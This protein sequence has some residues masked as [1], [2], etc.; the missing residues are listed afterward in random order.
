MRM[1]RYL[2]LLPL[3]AALALSACK[4][5]PPKTSEAEQA[6][7]V[8]VTRVEMRPIAGALAAS[9]DLVSR[10]EA[11][12][13]PEVGGFRAARVLVDV[14]D[15]VRRG[16]TLVQ[17]DPTMIR[18]QLAQQEALAAQA[19][20]NALQAEE[21]ATRVKGLDNEGVIAQEAIDQR[22]FQARAARATAN[23]QAAALK[24]MRT[25]VTKLSVGAPVSGL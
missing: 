6:R 10:E 7:A 13:Y 18:A 15:T 23:A 11:A 12:V 24:D 8:S 21:Q 17:L 19:E 25:R 1:R 22:R 3:A 4:S 9:G 20:A 5:P 2:V 14:G 16:Q